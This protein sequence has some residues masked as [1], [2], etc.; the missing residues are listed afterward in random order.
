M[1][2]IIPVASGKGG[3]GKTVF[4]ANIG[5]ALA[6]AGKTVILVDLD[7]GGSNLHTCLGEKNNKPGVGNYI[8]K[9]ERGL[10][11]LLV[12]TRTPQLY[13]IPGDSLLPGTANLP[14]FRKLK[15]LKE[16][17]ELIADY[18]IL[19][20]GSGSSYNTLDFFLT[21]SAGILVLSPETTSILNAYS[22]IKAAL[23]RLIYRS[24]PSRSEER[25]VVHRFMTERLEGTQQS[26]H[27]LIEELSRI[28]AESGEKAQQQL[29]SFLP[30][31]V[32]NMGKNQNDIQLGAKLRHVARKNLH[33]E[34]QYIG[35]L[36][37]DEQV[38]ASLLQRAPL[39]TLNPDGV[40]SKGLAPVASRIIREPVPTT[41]KLFDADEDLTQLAEEARYQH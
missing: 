6:R 15:I 12:E 8:Y 22:F 35:F 37:Y 19:D 28:S 26:T 34:V 5:V 1:T 18:V 31:V 25:E 17:H 14:Y 4:T 36:P 9:Q 11:A 32:L 16:L 39:L 41:P 13:F 33:V 21:S 29:S 24:F 27:A 7:L 2:T 23:F 20:L 10:E 38:S 40:F 3:V 30:R